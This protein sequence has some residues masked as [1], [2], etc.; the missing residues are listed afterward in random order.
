MT[1]T[2]SEPNSGSDAAAKHAD[3]QNTEVKARVRSVVKDQPTRPDPRSER[4][5][6]EILEA[7]FRLLRQEGGEKLTI[8]SV[9]K[10]AAISRGTFYRYFESKE[11]LMDSAT[12]YLRDQ[13]D[14][15]VRDA[16]GGIDDPQERFATFL[17]FALDNPGT[18]SSSRLLDTEPEFIL[19]YFRE[20]FSHFKGR[21]SNAL[22]PVFD[23]W[24]S[25]L[26]AKIDRDVVAELFVRF[27]LSAT[28]VPMTENRKDMAGELR[29]IARMIRNAPK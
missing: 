16:V 29:K 20:N 24:D 17:N 3:E 4:T 10:E 2:Y 21:V 27:A 5:V 11:D 15:G 18:R 14:A 25:E 19:N 28:L 9:C 13:T 22:T 26:E 8:R 7:T 12:R 6:G 1:Q 23:E